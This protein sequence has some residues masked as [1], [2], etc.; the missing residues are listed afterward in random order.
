MKRRRVLFAPE[1]VRDLESIYKIIAERGGPVRAQ[2]YMSRLE[3][4]CL[5]FDL[6]G[7]RGTARDDIRLGLRVTSFE[8]RITIAFKLTMDEVVFLRL[9]YAGAD[10]EASF[11]SD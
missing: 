2:N 10:W 9:F 6:A 1:A 3:T 8:R 11:P 4:Y 5:G 7:E